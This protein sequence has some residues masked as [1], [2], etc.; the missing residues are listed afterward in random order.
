MHQLINLLKLILVFLKK[1][2]ILH[3]LKCLSVNDDLFRYIGA[4]DAA[5]SL[6]KTKGFHLD[7]GATGT[8]TDS[9]G[10]TIGQFE[11]GSGTISNT[12][13]VASGAYK[14]ITKRKFVVVPAGG[15]DGWDVNYEV[16]R[17]KVKYC[18]I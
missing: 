2:L 8:Y 16:F 4:N 9:A 18:F 10:N 6:Y 5:T 7:S 3:Q 12:A 14:D 13:S 17:W 11:V 15:F 1:L